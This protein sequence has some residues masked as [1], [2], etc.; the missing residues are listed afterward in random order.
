MA[1]EWTYE[2]EACGESGPDAAKTT[3]TETVRMLG[4][5]WI[6]AEGHGA[7]PDGTPANTIMTVGYDPQKQ[8]FVGTFVG[9]MMTNLWIYDG[10]L[11]ADGKSLA[12]ESEGPSMSG[13]GTAKYKDVI[14]WVNDDERYF[15]AY[16]MGEDGKWSLFMNATYRRVK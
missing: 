16:V 2:H 1:G 3:G 7:L 4:D 8:R 9:S 15:K 6:V 12:L 10:A 14:E 11:E 5:V 13:Q